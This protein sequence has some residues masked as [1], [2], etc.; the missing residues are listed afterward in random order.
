MVKRQ[1]LNKII[2]LFKIAGKLK[3]TIRYSS[4]RGVVVRDSSADHSWSLAL[5]VL[6]T[7]A[8]LDLK[9]DVLKSLKLALI[10]DLVEAIAGDVD[11]T[12]IG[13]TITKAAKKRNEK[14]AMRKLLKLCPRRTAELI[15]QAWAEFEAGKTKEARFIRALDKI[16]TLTHLYTTGYKGKP[17]ARFTYAYGDEAV[18]NFCELADFLDVIKVNLKKTFIKNGN[19]K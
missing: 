8:E 11:A 6:V 3:R 2:D 1:E 15:G 9:I 19:W 17:Y 16:E 10:H 14:R 18:K 13:K 5:M 7:A 4:D 12:D